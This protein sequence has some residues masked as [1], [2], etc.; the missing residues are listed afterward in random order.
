MTL[1]HTLALYSGLTYL[2]A[3]GVCIPIL[4]VLGPLY[5]SRVTAPKWLLICGAVYMAVLVFRGVTIL[6]PGQIVTLSAISWV[7]PLKASADLGLMLILL[8]AVLRWRSPPPLISRLLAIAARNG[9]SDKG[10]VQMGFEAP[11][12]AAADYSASEDPHHAN[13]GPR[14]MR[15]TTLIGAVALIAAIV[16]TIVLN[17]SAAT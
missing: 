6:F 10:L 8:D 7:S 14:W 12:V 11:A 4:K 9:V 1:Q 5:P 3:A 16:A 2:A 15:L 13:L 17:S